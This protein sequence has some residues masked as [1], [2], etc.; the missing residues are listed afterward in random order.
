[1]KIGKE[2]VERTNFVIANKLTVVV[3]FVIV[4]SSPIL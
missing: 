1:M 4:V 2:M 3:Q